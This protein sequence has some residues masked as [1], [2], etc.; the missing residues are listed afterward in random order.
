MLYY[1]KKGKNITETH[2]KD[3]CSVGEGSV[4]DPTCPS[5]LQRVLE[6]GPLLTP[7]DLPGPGTVSVSP[8]LAGGCHAACGIFPEQ[9]S[10]LCL[11]H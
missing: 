5:G 3:L 4:T 9:G 11:L 6:E 1:F 7:G 10:N 8:A 2:T